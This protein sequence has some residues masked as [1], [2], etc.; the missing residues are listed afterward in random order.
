V[1]R[2]FK[3]NYRESMDRKASDTS[4]S[5]ERSKA[6]EFSSIQRGLFV[7]VARTGEERE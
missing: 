5:L 2:P 1:Q 6:F 3:E 7:Y 4:Q